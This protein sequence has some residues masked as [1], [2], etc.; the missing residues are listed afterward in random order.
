MHR[1]GGKEK[2]VETGPDSQVV[3]TGIR[4]GADSQDFDTGR[5]AI[6]TDSHNS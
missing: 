4:D 1:G 2:S 5:E 6:M 3:S